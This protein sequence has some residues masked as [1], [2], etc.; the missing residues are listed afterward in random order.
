MGRLY[1][2]MDKRG[3]IRLYLPESFE[4]I[5]LAADLLDDAEIRK[6]LE[7][8][9]EYIDSKEFVS[10]ERYFTK[11]LTDKSD[12]TWMKYSKSSLN[13]VFLQGRARGKIVD[14]LPECIHNLIKL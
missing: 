11:L 13:P 9:S 6:I 12:G 1:Q 14:I 10:W 3:G 5:I 2:L 8:P 7:D 4:W